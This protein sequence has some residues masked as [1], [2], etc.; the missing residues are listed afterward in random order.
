METPFHDQDCTA[1]KI[2]DGPFV[3][4]SQLKTFSQKEESQVKICVERF[5]E[6]VECVGCVLL[7]AF[8]WSTKILCALVCSCVVCVQCLR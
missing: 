7:C 2:Q 6:F 3:E 1:R 5:A 8:V 4:M